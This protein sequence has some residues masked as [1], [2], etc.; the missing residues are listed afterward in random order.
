MTDIVLM[1]FAVIGGGLTL[2]LFNTGLTSLG[3]E[4]EQMFR[5]RAEAR[6][7]KGEFLAENPS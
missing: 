4:N 3:F 1:I 5:L 7:T 6:E 2:E